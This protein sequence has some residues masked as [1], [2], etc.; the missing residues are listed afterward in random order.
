MAEIPEQIN[1]TV[2]A[3]LEAYEARTYMGDNLGVPMSQVADDCHRK[4]WYSLH[5]ASPQEHVTGQKQR[6]FNTGKIEEERLLDDLVLAGIEVVRVDPETGKQYRVALVEGWLRGKLDGTATNVPE[7]PVAVHVVECK[8]HNDKSFKDLIKKKLKESKPDHFAQCQLYMDAK[9][10]ERCLYLAVNRNDDMIYSERIEFDF[11]YSTKLQVKVEHIVRSPQAPP[12][13]FEDPESK[14]AFPCQWCNSRPQCHGGEFARVNCRT[15]LESSFE[16][17]P[18]VYCDFHKK[19]LNYQE[20][21]NG[22]KHHRY[23][24]SLVPGKQIDA[25]ADTRSV[26]Y[27]MNDGSTWTDGK[28]NNK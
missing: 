5:W 2:S 12:K 13:L 11:E 18:I 28:D 8:S 7:A 6:R 26:V 14:A 20:Q 24:P 9:G 16:P 3:I 27:K 15:C 1:H 21:Q 19:E 25:D 4:I 17:G 23:I 22:C 10:L